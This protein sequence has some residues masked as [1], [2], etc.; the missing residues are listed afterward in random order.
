MRDIGVS[1]QTGE[2]LTSVLELIYERTR[3]VE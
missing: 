1:F 2:H 3:V